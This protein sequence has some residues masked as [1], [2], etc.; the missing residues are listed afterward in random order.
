MKRIFGFLSAMCLIVA[1][2]ATAG[3]AR[4][5]DETMMTTKKPAPKQDTMMTTSKATKTGKK[6]MMTKKTPASKKSTNRRHRK[7]VKHRRL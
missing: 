7:T 5:Q 1:V 2:A 6:T 3:F 4:Q